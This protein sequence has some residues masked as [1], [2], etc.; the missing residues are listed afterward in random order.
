MIAAI[1]STLCSCSF[2]FHLFLAALN[3][4]PI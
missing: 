4:Y 3:R 2:L 1:S